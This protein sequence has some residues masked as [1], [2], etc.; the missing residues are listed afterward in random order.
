[1][2]Q[3][4]GGTVILC[5]CPRIPQCASSGAQ[6]STDQIEAAMAMGMNRGSRLASHD[7]VPF[8][9]LCR[10]REALIAT[11]ESWAC[12]GRVQSEV[13]LAGKCIIRSTCGRADQARKATQTLVGR[14]RIA[15]IMGD[16]LS[17]ACPSLAVTLMPTA[18]MA[19]GC[20]PWTRPR[21][22]ETWSAATRCEG[23]LSSCHRAV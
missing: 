12:W 3:Q 15:A 19:A 7:T 6:H 20:T 21:Q 14:A 11:P 9:G 4:H 2:A 5:S 17:G 16:L 1:M 22:E 18:G 8:Y 13:G 23:P 10:R